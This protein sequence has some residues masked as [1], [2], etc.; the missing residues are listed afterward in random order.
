M[1]GFMNQKVS[2]ATSAGVMGDALPNFAGSVRFRW[3][4]GLV[5]V[6]NAPASNHLEHDGARISFHCGEQQAVYYGMKVG[7][8]SGIN[9]DAERRSMRKGAKDEDEEHN[10]AEGSHAH[11]LD[12]FPPHLPS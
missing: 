1:D 6:E 8:Q 5:R 11:D 12:V 2:T 10:G 7:I 3:L 9:N 4:R